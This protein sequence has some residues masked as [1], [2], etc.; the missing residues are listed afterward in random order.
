MGRAKTTM[1]SIM[2]VRLARLKCEVRN[3]CCIWLASECGAIGMR[4]LATSAVW[5][6]IWWGG[7]CDIASDNTAK[8]L[9]LIHRRMLLWRRGMTII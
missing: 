9:R 2:F 7:I 1:L 5:S 8:S 3:V 4:R 6:G